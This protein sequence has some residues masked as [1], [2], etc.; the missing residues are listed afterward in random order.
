MCVSLTRVPAVY[1]YY[2]TPETYIH[3]NQFPSVGQQAQEKLNPTQ[4]NC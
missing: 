4:L 1:S 2:S 3:N